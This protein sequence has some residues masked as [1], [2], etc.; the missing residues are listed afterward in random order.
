MGRGAR[1]SLLGLYSFDNSIFDN[2]VIPN[3]MNKD[4]L[5][6]NLLMECSELEILYPDSDFMKNAIGQW[7]LKE[8]DKWIRMFELLSSNTNPLNDIDIVETTNHDFTKNET[9]TDMTTSESLNKVNG[10]NDGLV[11]RNKVNDTTTRNPNLTNT[12]S[13]EK[14]KTIKGLS[15]KYLKQ[16]VIFKELELRNLYNIDDIIIDDFKTRFC[17][18]IY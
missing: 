15:S 16:D 3:G 1:L 10:W 6:Q 18:L 11:D 14:V 2:F 17:L 8:L 5:L 12:D 4:M 13:G 7:S 9:G